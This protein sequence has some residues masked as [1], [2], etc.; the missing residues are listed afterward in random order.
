MRLPPVLGGDQT[1]GRDCG[2]GVIERIEPRGGGHVFGAA[3]APG[4]ADDE[5]LLL[6]RRQHPLGR[7]DRQRRHNRV[8]RLRC[9]CTVFEP[10][11]EQVVFAAVR[12][13]ALAATVLHEQARLLQQDAALR[14]GQHHAAPLGALDDLRVVEERV[15]AEQTELEAAAAVLRAVAGALVAARLR[16]KRHNLAAKVH[17]QV[18][19][20]PLHLHRHRRRL[21]ARLDGESRLAVA[22]RP[23]HAG[24]HPRHR[25]RAAGEDGLAA[26]VPSPAVGIV[27]QHDQPLLVARPVE[28]HLSREYDQRIQRRPRRF[29]PG[30]RFRRRVVGQQQARAKQQ[31]EAGECE[32]IEH[33]RCPSEVRR[34]G[35][36][37]CGD[38]S[39]STA[40]ACRQ[41]RREAREL[42]AV[43]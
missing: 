39:A 41:G 10:L 11:L 14:L 40:P 15:E 37:G 31:G 33:D 17:Q 36:A 32:A 27:A 20:R 34:D 3:V 19:L 8:G 24:I 16:Q 5:L 42:W 13:E 22:D 30:D 29:R 23:D 12:L 35:W 26:E 21:P 38:C 1:G 4:G 2:D 9:R 25:G 43:Y 6:A 18:G 28:V 7:K